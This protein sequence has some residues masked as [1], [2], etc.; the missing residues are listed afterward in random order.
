MNLIN[1]LQLKRMYTFNH[2][3]PNHEE[4]NNKV[5]ELK[6][7]DDEEYEKIHI[8]EDNTNPFEEEE[9]SSN[10]SSNNFNKKIKKDDNIS[11][12]SINS[13]N[14]INGI[15]HKIPKVTLTFEES[16]NNLKNNFKKLF[17]KK[18]NNNI[19]N[20]F[21]NNKNFRQEFITNKNMQL[22]FKFSD[23]IR[24]IYENQLQTK[25]EEK[26]CDINRIIDIYITK[27][28]KLSKKRKIVVKDYKNLI[29]VI[30]AEILINKDD[31]Q[32]KEFIMKKRTETYKG[33]NK[34]DI[35]VDDC[36]IMEINCNKKKKQVFLDLGE[37]TN[38][39]I[40]LEQNLAKDASLK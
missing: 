25:I 18:S 12:H 15:E 33:N 26:N 4:N 13:M 28:K 22:I 35:N 1:Q 21:L 7:S 23:I 3:I 24:E 29:F 2:V 31:T 10:W 38:A 5:I 17:N 34:I 19:D 39:L 6:E 9:S 37:V 40:L 16:L 11:N 36:Y 27:I 14:S 32:A 30:G 20:N 8:V